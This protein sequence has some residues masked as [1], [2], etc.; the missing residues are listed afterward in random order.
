MS[1][2][3]MTLEQLRQLLLEQKKLTIEYLRSN[4]YQYNTNSTDDHSHSLPI[5]RDK[6][7]EVGM[8]A[9]FP[10]AYNTLKA[11]LPEAD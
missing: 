7:M 2:I 11:Y 5:D 1:K 3:T 9:R 8:K 4:S 10:D 6:M